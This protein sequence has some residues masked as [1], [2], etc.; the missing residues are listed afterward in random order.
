MRWNDYFAAIL[1]PSMQGSGLRY[2]Q[3]AYPV[4]TY[5]EGFQPCLI[6][7]NGSSVRAGLRVGI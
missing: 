2:L 3:R 5:V 1:L 7:T 6:V 4:S